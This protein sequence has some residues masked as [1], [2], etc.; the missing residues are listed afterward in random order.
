V[1]GEGQRLQKVLA[2]AGVGSRRTVEEWISAGRIRVNGST[3]RLGQ[4]IDPASDV[5]EL[6]G[7]RVPLGAELVHY[8]LNKPPGVVTSAAD[9]EGRRTVLDIVDIPV[10]VWPVGRLDIDTE[11]A[12]LLTNDGELTF[13]L[14]HP[15]YEVPKTYLAD[16]AGA[17]GARAVKEL[18]RGVPLEDGMTKPAE[19]TLI[20]RST[21]GS[22]VRLTITEGRNHQVKRMFDAVG[23]PVTRL[24][25]I[26]VGPVSLGRLKPGTV[27]RLS[28]ADV[29]ALYR[30]C[31]L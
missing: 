9:P 29:R 21:G 6:D 24:V 26:G 1:S 22:L 11:G 12:L 5:V 14:T 28:M 2:R 25:R 15:S 7:S 10:R 20:E 16:V 30:S 17:L 19:A 8:L 23:H 3:A 31:D 13:R 4:R 27:R 18:S